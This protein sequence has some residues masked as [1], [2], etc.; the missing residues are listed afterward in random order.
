MAK[1][2]IS[3]EAIEKFLDGHNDQQRIVNLDYKYDWDYIK[4]FYRDENDSRCVEEYPFFPFVWA[5]LTVCTKL[6]N[7]NRNELKTLM[8]R[9]GIGVKELDITNLQ[10]EQCDEMLDGYRYLFYAKRKMSYSDFLDFF[11]K[12]GYP[13]YSKDDSQKGSKYYLCVTP[14]EQF[15]I[16]TGKRF[17]KGYE[18]YNELLRMIF[19]LETEGL[20]PTRHRIKLN[21]IR[22]N[23][24]VQIKDRYFE[25]F[26]KIFRVEGETDAEKNASELNVIEIMLKAIKYFKPDIIT[27]HNGENFDWNFIIERCKALGTDI[28]TLSRKYF[29]GEVIFKSKRESILK[30]GGEIEKF[31][32]TVVPTIITTDSLHAVR[33]AQALDSNMKEANL[34]YVTIYSEMVKQNRVYVPGEFIDKTL[35][36]TEKHFAFNNENGDW[37]MVDKNCGKEFVFDGN[38]KRKNIPVFNNVAEGYELVT[39]EYIVERYLY[40][41]LWECD[42]VEHRYNTPN[43]LICKMLPVPF[44]K[45]CT[46]GTAGQWKALLLAWSYE[47]NLAIPPFSERKSFTGGL[48][49]LLYVGFVDKVAKFDYNSLYPSIDLTWHVS[50]EKDL[51]ESML[52]FLEHVL[53]QREKY[54]KLKKKAGKEA[55]KIKEK[56]QNHEYATKEE[57]KKL[58]AE[59]LRLKG[60]ESFND[61]KQLPLKILGNSFFGS[62]GAPNVFPWGSTEC[63]ERTTCIGRQCLRLMIYYFNSHGYKPI[64]GDSFTP[65]TPL[66]IKYKDSGL[67]DI[68]PIEEL[69]DASS[70]NIDALGREYDY[71]KK[72]YYVLCRSGWVEPNYIYRHKTD[73]DIYEITEGDTS[74][75]VT[76]DHS[77]FNDKQEKIKPSEIDENT[78]LEYYREKILPDCNLDCIKTIAKSLGKQVA[79][80]DTFDRVPIGI[81]NSN[82]STMKTFYYAFMKNYREDTEYSK[83]CLAGLQYIKRM[84]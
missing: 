58:N 65:D 13:I 71:S 24:P 17:F 39:G 61:K 7:G 74:I 21:G 70:I 64:V 76:E 45:C 26:N 83:T 6:C 9:Y 84:I 44:Q 63:A 48:S 57:A 73:K 37:Y 16:S 69:I 56:L 36:D 31:H 67:I 2:E 1:K 43:F 40:D 4:V 51:M 28:E 10:G 52:A 62:Y 15:L 82:K 8:S 12:T 20:D 5:K 77:L 47:N 50:D 41:D 14:Q 78:K 11:K 38:T 23:R 19:D 33:R 29:N 66:F 35:V 3:L 81:L 34:K 55:E 75:E 72:D 42:K 22:L 18:D 59:M 53:T 80:N 54:K 60:E 27:A 79:E 49:R 46:M 32:Q 30:L 68:K 25:N